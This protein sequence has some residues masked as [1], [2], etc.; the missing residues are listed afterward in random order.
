M[1]KEK[2]KE[3]NSERCET[4]DDWSLLY[5]KIITENL[6]DDEKNKPQ[7]AAIVDITDELETNKTENIVEYLE[8]DVLGFLRFGGVRF[9]YG[10]PILR[11][12][13]CPLAPPEIWNNILYHN[14]YIQP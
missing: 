3:T 12:A 10:W 8:N 2:K 7:P 5:E 1:G 9:W 6:D 13:N 14:I 4:I 11:G